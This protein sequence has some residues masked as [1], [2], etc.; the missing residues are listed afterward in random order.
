M[1]E[2]EDDVVHR[3]ERLDTALFDGVASQT[4]QRDRRSLLAVQRA[5]ARRFGR[6]VYLEIGSHLGGSIQPHLRDRRCVRIYSIDPRPTS[7]PDDRSPGCRVDYPNNSTA[8]MLDALAKVSPNGIEKIRCFESDA[9]A[10]NRG[11]IEPRPHLAFIDGEHTRRAVLSDFAFCR[12]VLEPAGA[13]VFDDFPIVYPA[14]LEIR[15]AL[16]LDGEDIVAL[17]LEGKAFALFRDAA[18]VRSD[19]FLER[20]RARSRFTLARYGWKLRAKGLLPGRAGRAARAA[21]RG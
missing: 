14:L 16:R 15:R 18:L 3:V 20:C 1:V 2:I 10:V 21:L 9:A 8:A 11:A 7:Q 4:S 17:R 5:V 19:A 13:V 6:Y 12:A